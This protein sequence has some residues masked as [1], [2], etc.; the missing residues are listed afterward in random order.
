MKFTVA[1]A[2]YNSSAT[3]EETLLSVIS[4]KEADVEVVIV[5]G[6]STDSTLQILRYYSDSVKMISEPDNGVYDAMNKAL[7]LATGDFV[8]FLGADDHLLS[9]NTISEVASHIDNK[10]AI[11]YGDVYRNSRNDIYMGKFSKYKLACENICHQAIFYPKS[12]YKKMKYDLRF[13][14]YAD[15][16]YNLRNWKNHSFKYVPICISYYNCTGLSGNDKSGEKFGKDMMREVKQNLGWT[17]YLIRCF[18]KIY[19]G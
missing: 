15:Y 14:V 10:N 13:P 6:G 1:I 7:D 17:C 5:D 3:I 4:Q 9:S 12:V 19:K 8:L 11:Y 18:Y 16:V 2:V